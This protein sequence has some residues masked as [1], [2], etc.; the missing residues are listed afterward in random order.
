MPRGD[1]TGPL[2]MGPMSGRRAGYCTGIDM[3]GY[4]NASAR[5][6]FGRNR[7]FGLGVPGRGWGSWFNTSGRPGRM[8]T[9]RYGFWTSGRE[10]DQERED[11][12]TKAAILQSE[13]EA[14]IQRIE[15]LEAASSAR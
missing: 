2:G 6:G 3:P 12:R 9:G 10:M 15:D 8:R 13:L 5:Y 7:G 1:G 14:V 11:L 4:A